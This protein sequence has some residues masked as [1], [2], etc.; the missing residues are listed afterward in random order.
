MTTSAA[1]YLP[2]NT[3][4]DTLRDAV[5]ACRGCDLYRFASRAVFG[6]GRARAHLM[7]VGEQPGNE[8]DL[9]GHPFVGPAGRV[10]DQAL[11][12]AHIPRDDIYVTNAVKHFKFR[13]RGSRRIHDRPTSQEVRACRPWLE[14]ELRTITP[15][16]LVLL[17]AT[18]A[19]SLL[20]SGFRVTRHRGTLLQT[21]WA[22]AT[23]VTVHPASVL[24]VPD[25]GL[26]QQARDAFFADI[27]RVGEH[28][29]QS[30]GHRDAGHQERDLQDPAAEH[31]HE[32]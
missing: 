28:Y 17:G 1:D 25:P 20:G 3:S 13:M 12:A 14:A 21:P 11:E 5:Q 24:R 7:M 9:T 32:P 29:H 18:A 22:E 27:R 6:E 10:L 23:L 2:E 4:L 26:R 15:R 31:R 8:E 30:L 16:I 19:Q